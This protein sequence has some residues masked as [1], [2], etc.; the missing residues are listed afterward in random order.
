MLS[1]RARKRRLASFVAALATVGAAAAVVTPPAGAAPPNPP[2]GC[3]VV[4]NTPAGRTGAPQ[5]QANK[6]ATF[7]RLCLQ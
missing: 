2:P 3:S 5:A 6:A 1:L 4:V 7:D